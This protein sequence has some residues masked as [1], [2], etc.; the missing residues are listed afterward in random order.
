MA[1]VVPNEA[2]LPPTSKY[3]CTELFLIHLR[4]DH[5][6]S[7]ILSFVALSGMLMAAGCSGGG[8]GSALNGAQPLAPTTGGSTSGAVRGTA[9]IS[10]SFKIPAAQAQKILANKGRSPQYLSPGTT[11]LD[12]LL[13][14]GTLATGSQGLSGTAQLTG[15][16][17]ETGIAGQT[18]TVTYLSASNTALPVQG[19]TLTI[20]HLINDANGTP[21]GSTSAAF[22]IT[23]PPQA[24]GTILTG[25]F[26]ASAAAAANPASP[27]NPAGF[28]FVAGDLVTFTPTGAS[29]H[30]QQFIV[31][32]AAGSTALTPTP[33]V[34]APVPAT[35]Y[36]ATASST[37]S[38]GFTSNVADSD[39]YY[40]FNITVNGLTPSLP[41]FLGIVTTDH[42]NHDY[43]LS[44][45]QAA[46]PTVANGLATYAFTL[47]PVVTGVYV[48]APT[49]INPPAN[50]SQAAPPVALVGNVGGTLETTVFATDELGY[51]IP[52]QSLFVQPANNPTAAATALISISPVTAGA[53]TFKVYGG[54][55][56]QT[57]NLTEAPVLPATIAN[58]AVAGTVSIGGTLASDYASYA[59][60]FFRDVLT[61]TANAGPV[62]D[63][64]GANA[65]GN[66]VNVICGVAT[67]GV[68]WAAKI[69]SSALTPANGGTDAVGFTFT[70]G[71]NFP[72]A[73]TTVNLP[74]VNCVPGI[75]GVVN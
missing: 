45:A 48:P 66:P 4:K 33:V 42:F 32:S 41:L 35:V 51:T 34:N 22:T 70:P 24:N 53:L 59:G 56:A 17:S 73:T 12:V 69:N 61:S 62:L 39:G 20:T 19:Q 27:P 8:A 13:G 55:V 16:V 57:T 44:E 72:S 7:R 11:G 67:A 68:T 18:A 1:R 65:A 9:S 60:T 40:T 26:A 30:G 52:D 14:D 58:S 46:T 54:A 21:V 10:A 49:V 29:I 75:G 3:L 37:V 6:T 28:N 64:S 25:T 2:S 38:Y 50:G 71:T 74:A 23:A 31:G 43:V 47:K 63:P 36:G 5:M 15:T